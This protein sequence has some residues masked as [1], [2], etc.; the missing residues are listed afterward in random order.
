M[1][2]IVNDETGMFDQK[3]S[4]ELWPEDPV[5]KEHVEKYNQNHDARGR[6]A[7]GSGGAAGGSATSP[8]MGED[9]DPGFPD[10]VK[11]SNWEEG[12]VTLEEKHA[13]Q[14]YVGADYAFINS[15]LRYPDTGNPEDMEMYN[16]FAKHVESAIQKQPALKGEEIVYRGLRLNKEQKAQML[17]PGATVIDKGFMSTSISRETAQSF[18]DTVLTIRVPK[19]QKALKVWDVVDTVTTRTE[20]EILLPRNT[21]LKITRVRE[22]KSGFLGMNKKTYVEARVVDKNE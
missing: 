15:Y 20:R 3:C 16:R 17:Q 10:T 8:A 19:G 11:P 7:S 9:D 21:M 6:F 13:V 12:T 1:K 18:G 2:H 22:E 4:L 14:T 5:T